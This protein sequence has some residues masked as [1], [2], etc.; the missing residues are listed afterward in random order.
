MKIKIFLFQ[1]TP[2]FNER[3]EFMGAFYA[4]TLFVFLAFS[5]PKR[6]DNAMFVYFTPPL[7]H[8]AIEVCF[9]VNPPL[10][11]SLSIPPTICIID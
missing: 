2:A 10:K 4:I 7:H 6:L 3:H 8:E 9:V 11:A 5:S 1:Q